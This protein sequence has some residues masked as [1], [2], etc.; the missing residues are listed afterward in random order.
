MQRLFGFL[1]EKGTKLVLVSGFFIN[2]ETNLISEPLVV[3]TSREQGMLHS[4]YIDILGPASTFKVLI[5]AR[6]HV[7]VFVFRSVWNLL[8]L[9]FLRR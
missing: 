9:F 5:Q 4:S 3:V 7:I 2:P 8:P 1:I 6:L